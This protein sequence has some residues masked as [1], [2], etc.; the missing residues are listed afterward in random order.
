MED[1]LKIMMQLR[2]GPKLD[3]EQDISK[4]IPRKYGIYGWFNKKDD[5]VEYIGSAT[6]E[7]GLYQRIINQHLKE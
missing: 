1:A 2:D 3:P 5:N 7:G 4:Y 6:G